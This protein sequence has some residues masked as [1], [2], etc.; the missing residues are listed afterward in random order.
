MAQPV[1]IF[2]VISQ[3][4][5]SFIHYTASLLPLIAFIKS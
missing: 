2:D 1:F 3:Q 4:M 5:L